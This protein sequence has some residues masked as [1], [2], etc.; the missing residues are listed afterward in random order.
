M[1]IITQKSHFLGLFLIQTLFLIIWTSKIV[2]SQVL[3]SSNTTIVF[4]FCITSSTREKGWKNSSKIEKEYGK[5][6]QFDF[7]HFLF[8]TNGWKAALTLA[9]WNIV[10]SALF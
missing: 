9:K 2:N 7:G 8:V 6:T 5:T 1:V 4:A 3:A 10:G